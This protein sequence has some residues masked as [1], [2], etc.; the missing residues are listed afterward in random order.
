MI[1][2]LDEKSYKSEKERRRE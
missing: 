1:I 2:G